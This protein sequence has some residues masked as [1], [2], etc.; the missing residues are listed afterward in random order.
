MDGDIVDKILEESVAETTG[1]SDKSEVETVEN[2]I[3]TESSAAS[4][5][6]TITTKEAELTNVVLEEKQTT[7]NSETELLTDLAPEFQLTKG[8]VLEKEEAVVDDKKSEETMDVSQEREQTLEGVLEKDAESA[9][10]EPLHEEHMDVTESL[11]VS[12]KVIEQDVL[13]TPVVENTTEV[14]ASDMQEKIANDVGSNFIEQPQTEISDTIMDKL[15]QLP[16][17]FNVASDVA[18]PM[19]EITG[20]TNS[21]SLQESTD[22]LHEAAKKIEPNKWKPKVLLGLDFEIYK[23]VA[24]FFLNNAIDF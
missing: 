6:S 12:E 10:L 19:S 18:E 9:G 22:I 13:L 11:D 21:G 4:I 20:S 23:F 1:T 7:E 2:V 17:N 24:V 16:D 3:V 14:Q 15:E 8:D 5:K